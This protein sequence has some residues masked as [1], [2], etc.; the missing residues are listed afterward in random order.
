MAQYNEIIQ[1]YEDIIDIVDTFNID[2]A[3]YLR[4]D[5]PKLPSFKKNNNLS[6]CFVWSDTPQD[7]D[8][9]K[10]IVYDIHNLLKNRKIPY[11][12][13]IIPKDL[14]KID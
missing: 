5:A 12:K 7:H 13:N 11:I 8:Y 6:A 10:N 14:F 3:E 1:T 4:I 2:A 9:W